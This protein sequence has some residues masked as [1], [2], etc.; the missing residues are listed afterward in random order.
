[1]SRTVDLH[2]QPIY[3]QGMEHGVYY[4]KLLYHR[5]NRQPYENLGLAHSP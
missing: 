5:D 2:I 1:M 3:K 4:Y